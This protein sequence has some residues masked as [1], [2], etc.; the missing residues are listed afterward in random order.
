MLP[1]LP[2]TVQNTVITLL[3]RSGL[4]RNDWLR[5]QLSKTIINGAGY[6]TT[7]RPRPLSLLSDYTSWR[8]LND[9]SYSGRHLPPATDEAMQA[10]PDAKDV[11]SLFRR[12]AFTPAT[13]TSVMFMFFAQWFTDSFLRTD[14][15]DWRRNDSNHDIDLCQI[16][17]T[18]FAQTELL[19]SKVGGRLRSQQLDGEEYPEFLFM[20]REPGTDAPLV[21][22]PHFE[23]LHDLSF[24]TDVLLRDATDAHKATFF[25]V[26][27]EHGNSTIGNTVMNVVFLREHN[28]VAGILATEH[29]SWDDERVFQTTRNILIVLLLK[30]VVEEYIVHIAPFEFPLKMVSLIA[31]GERWNRQNWCAVEFNLLYRWHML[32]PETIGTGSDALDPRGFRN[33]N[34]LVLSE[35]I[36]AL[37][38]LCSAERAGR[39][40]LGNTPSFLVDVRDPNWP[41]AEWRSI[42]LM[43]NARLRSYN[44]YREA[45][46][47]PRLERIEDLTGSDDVRARL[48]AL[49]DD[50]DAVEWYVGIFAE[51]YPDYMMMGELLTA[52][53]ANDAFTQALSNPLLARHIYDDDA[54]FTA[55][56]RAI[57][58]HTTSVHDIVTR[59]ATHPGRVHVSFR[60]D[61]PVD[62][63]GV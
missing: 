27:L 30:L 19:R 14:R 10:L 53:V 46:G 8:S 54:T 43:R 2:K 52:M 60:C 47:L 38:A 20:P 41:S 42:S 12:D 29:P 51:D 26:G 40:G 50:V 37:T 44:D 18:K 28:R 34:P 58:D 4:G 16:Y 61:G 45:Y 9:R 48:Q 13:D 22:Q 21:P 62:G 15:V 36:E 56:G 31:D 33:N 3:G 49:Y 32:V 35:G 59:N 24:L 7:L 57:I 63:G 17:G 5:D 39:I 1:S 11:L 23:G 6:D 25:A 55:T